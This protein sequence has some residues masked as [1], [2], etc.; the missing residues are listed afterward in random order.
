M[1]N[2]V[3]TI[4]EGSVMLGIIGIFLFLNLQFGLLIQSYFVLI[5]PIPIII[6]TIK[7]GV[8]NGLILIFAAITLTLM[9]GQFTTFFYTVTGLILGLVYG[10]GILKNHTNDWIISISIIVNSISIFIETYL[11]AKLFGYDILAEINTIVSELSKIPEFAEI[12]NVDAL[13]LSLIPLLLISMSILQT[14][15]VHMI[16]IVLLRRLKISYRKAKPVE[17]FR[18][19]IWAGVIVTIALFA[20]QLLTTTNS[21][22]FQVIGINLSVFSQLIAVFY[23]FCLILFYAKRSGKKF[24]TTFAL[25]GFLFLP[26]VIIYVFIGLGLLDCF[27]DIRKRIELITL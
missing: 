4:T 12:L 23:G 2:Q 22:T 24:L 20:G 6:Y 13:I 5:F 25:L 15:I 8:K 18:L 10:Y 7:Y 14:I 26:S 21:T 1:K 3:R 17:D 9:L 11:L 27:T 19:P 16:S